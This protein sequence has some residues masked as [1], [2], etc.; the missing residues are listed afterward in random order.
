MTKLHYGLLFKEYGRCPF[1]NFYSNS[2]V[3]HFYSYAVAMIPS[4]TYVLVLV[5][6]RTYTLGIKVVLYMPA[7]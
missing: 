4:N 2:V 1:M 6:V 5:Y 3:L 7:K